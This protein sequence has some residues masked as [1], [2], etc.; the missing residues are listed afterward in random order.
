MAA[1]KPT[2]ARGH[3]KLGEMPGTDP[4]A[5]TGTWPWRH[6]DFELVAFRIVRR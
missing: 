6:L 3:Q 2:N 4:R 1:Y 5:F